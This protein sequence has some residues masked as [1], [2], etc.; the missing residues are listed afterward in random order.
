MTLPALLQAPSPSSLAS[1]WKTLF[2]HG[3]GPVVSLTFSAAAGFAALAYRAPPG[4]GRGEGVAPPRT[5]YAIAAL[6]GCGLAPYTLVLM[7]GVNEELALRGAGGKGRG[8]GET[9]G[10]VVRWGRLSL[11]RGVLLLGAAG[12]G[13]WGCVGERV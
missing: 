5:L 1:Q 9:R 10:L 11:V 12:V 3:I 13:M 8:E 2:D 7:G 4:T 6:L